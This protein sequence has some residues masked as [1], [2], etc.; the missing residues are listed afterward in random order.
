MNH[1]ARLRAEARTAVSPASARRST[2]A[3]LR[4]RAIARSPLAGR[5][6]HVAVWT[7]ERM[8]VWGGSGRGRRSLGDGASYDPA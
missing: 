3:R 2:P 6:G 8:L 1:R 5:F 7:G 4:W